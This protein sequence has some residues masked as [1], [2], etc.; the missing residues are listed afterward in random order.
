VIFDFDQNVLAIR[1]FVPRA[2]GECPRRKSL[3]FSSGTFSTLVA[4]K[5][6]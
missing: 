6:P 2:L 4:M 3:A 5:K 1:P